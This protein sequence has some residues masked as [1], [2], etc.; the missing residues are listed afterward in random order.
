MT[1][2]CI[3]KS[4][5]DPSDIGVRPIPERRQCRIWPFSP[6]NMGARTW[7]QGAAFC[8][9]VGDGKTVSRE[10]IELTQRVQRSSTRRL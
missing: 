5:S 7:A 8:P 1:V 2:N 9:G 10:E 3:R 4:G 6:D